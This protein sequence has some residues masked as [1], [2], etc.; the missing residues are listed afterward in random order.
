LVCT[1]QMAAAAASVKTVKKDYW[2]PQLVRAAT[3]A[4]SNQTF[5]KL[6]L[7]ML[8]RDIEDKVE[9]KAK[10]SALESRVAALEAQSPPAHK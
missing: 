3:L 5:N 6:L 8:W 10:I 1:S 9:M 7:A 4:T 2:Y